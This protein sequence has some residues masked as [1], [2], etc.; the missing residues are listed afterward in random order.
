MIHAYAYNPY[1]LGLVPR[2]KLGKITLECLIW[3]Q[4]KIYGMPLQH[5]YCAIKAVCKASGTPEE[6]VMT[7]LMTGDNK[8]PE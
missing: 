3:K 1:E 7:N 4:I 2:L 5:N 8:T 6:F